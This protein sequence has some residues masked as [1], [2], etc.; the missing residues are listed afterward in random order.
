MPFVEGESLRDRLRHEKQLP[1]GDEAPG[2]GQIGRGR[3]ECSCGPDRR[4]F[5]RGECDRVPP[6]SD[7]R[8]SG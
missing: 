1:V 6:M 5:G 7:R 4:S 8:P 2:A 3:F